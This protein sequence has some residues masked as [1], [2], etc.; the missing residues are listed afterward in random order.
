MNGTASLLLLFVAAGLLVLAGT[1]IGRWR[2]GL[3]SERDTA[4]MAAMTGGAATFLLTVLLVTPLVVLPAAAIGVLVVVWL[5]RR[6]WLQLGAFL[7]GGGTL[8][9]TMQ[10]Y[11]LLNDVLDPAVISGWSPEPL[12]IG[13]AAVVLGMWFVVAR[14]RQGELER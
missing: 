12:A 10:A 3:P 9:A 2:G 5:D 13:V 8:V 1:G 7:V 11:R 4:I 14:A 6:E